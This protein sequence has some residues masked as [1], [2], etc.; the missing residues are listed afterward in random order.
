VGAAGVHE[1]EGGD[2]VGGLRRTIAL[3]FFF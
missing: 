3:Q 2:G 1:R